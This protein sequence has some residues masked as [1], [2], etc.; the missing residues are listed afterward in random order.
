VRGEEFEGIS[1]LT[2]HSLLQWW[3]DQ[4]PGWRRAGRIDAD[5]TPFDMQA[6]FGKKL[7]GTRIDAMFLL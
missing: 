6:A 1:R 4:G 5:P 3:I 7:Y 2:P